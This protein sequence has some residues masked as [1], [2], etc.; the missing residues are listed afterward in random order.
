MYVIPHFFF[1]LFLKGTGGGLP[2]LYDIGLGLCDAAWLT[3]DENSGCCQL[4]IPR[5]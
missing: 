2:D 4:L 5:S 3:I 1:F